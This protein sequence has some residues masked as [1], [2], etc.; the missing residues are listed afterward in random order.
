MLTLYPLSLIP[1]LLC[2][3]I[4]DK[5]HKKHRTLFS[6]TK[7]KITTLIPL[8][9]IFLAF[10]SVPYAQQ[11]IQA[12][13]TKTNSYPKFSILSE[14]KDKSFAYFLRSLYPFFVKPRKDTCS[15]QPSKPSFFFEK[16]SMR[17]NR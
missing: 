1:C 12:E 14:E 8:K 15:A 4:E 16:S 10:F 13:H 9:Q 6:H 5:D 7:K 17:S 3:L 11:G 2:P